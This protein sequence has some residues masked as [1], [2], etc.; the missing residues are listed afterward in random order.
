MSKAEQKQLSEIIDKLEE[1]RKKE[2]VYNDTII[3]DRILSKEDVKLL[4]SKCTIIF[5]QES[6]LL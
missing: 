4:I 6:V 5:K 1:I 3:P 2:S